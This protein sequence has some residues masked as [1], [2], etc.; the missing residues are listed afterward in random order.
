MGLR[1]QVPHAGIFPL[2]DSADLKP[3]PEELSACF[4]WEDGND[5]TREYAMQEFRN[6]AHKGYVIP[7]ASKE[8]LDEHLHEPAVVSP[9]HILAK[10]RGSKLKLRTIFDGKV[11]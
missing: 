11:S 4:P 3:D 10:V 7:F 2:H 9:I 5:L 8:S 1:L 6:H